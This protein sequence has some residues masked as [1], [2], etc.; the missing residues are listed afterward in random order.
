MEHFEKRWEIIRGKYVGAR[1][2]VAGDWYLVEGSNNL[3]DDPTSEK[4]LQRICDYHNLVVPAL[5]A[6]WNYWSDINT[7]DP[8]AEGHDT[9]ELMKEAIEAIGAEPTTDKPQ[10][11]TE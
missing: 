4:T 11:G 9:I 5:R 1:L 6:V 2:V 7:S 8:N 10:G 3:P